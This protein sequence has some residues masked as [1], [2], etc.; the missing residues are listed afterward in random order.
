[1]KKVGFIYD[2]IFLKHEM[3][4][5]H[6]ES[7]Q[8]L[9]AILETLKASECWDRL[10]HIKPRRAG[11]EDILAVHTGDY[12]KRMQNFTGFYDGDTYISKHTFEAALFAAGAV[13]EAI[14]RC[15]KGE[16]ER[17]FCAVRPPGHHAE[18]DAAMGF[19]IF[20]NIAIGARYAQKAGYR[21]VFIVDF[22]VHH[23]N[24]TQHIFEDDDSVFYF[25][26][27]QYPHYPGTGSDGER[28]TGKGEGYTY[29]IPMPYGT[30]D[31]D[32]FVAYRDILPRLVK[33]FRPDII[34]VSAGYDILLQDPLS[35]F[36]VTSEGMRSILR[37]ILLRSTAT[38]L[39]PLPYVFALEGGYDLKALGD[40]VLQTIKELLEP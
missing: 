20:N 34:L 4:P 26:T 22:D 7:P 39:P 17:A 32:F 15:K 6:P 13:I 19:C 24:G 33:N 10:I 9:I 27:H 3:P 31:K 1:M 30:G 40:S 12:L 35:G 18:A 23:G 29:N 25:S 8:R 2:D 36:K 16:I 38:Y 37:G 14:G 11:D 5:G 21:K 28:G